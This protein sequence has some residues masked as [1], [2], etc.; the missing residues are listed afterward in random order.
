[1]IDGGATRLGPVRT[2]FLVGALAAALSMAAAA[3]ALLASRRFFFTDDYVTYYMPG[4]REIARLLY[5]GQFPFLTDRLWN[6]GALLQEGQF[7]LFNPVSL[8]LYA[9][10]GKIDDLRLAAAVFSLAH[11]GIFGGGAY[12][13]GRTIGCSR[14]HAFLV[15]L[16]APL[17]DFVFYWAATNWVSILVSM[18]WLAWAWGFLILTARR[19]AYV[20]PA[21]AMVAMVLV[22]GWPFADLALLISVFLAADVFLLSGFS[23]SRLA[24]AAWLAVALAAGVLLAAPALAP[25]A[26]YDAGAGRPVLFG[27]WASELAGLL[28][29]GVP[30]FVTHWGYFTPYEFKDVPQPTVFVAWFAPLALVNADWKTLMGKPAS[31]LVLLLAGTLAA[32]SMFPGVWQFRWMFRLLPYYQFAVLALSCLALTQADEQG[33]RWRFGWSSRLVLAEIGLAI[34]QFMPLAWF[35]VLAGAAILACAAVGGRLIA[36]RD[37]AWTVFAVATSMAAFVGPLILAANAGYPRFPAASAL[38]TGAAV[39]GHDAEGPTR[40]TI[41]EGGEIAGRGLAAW[42]A[43]APAG[44]SLY[45][46]GTNLVGYSNIPRPP[47]VADFCAGYIGP[48]CANLATRVTRPIPPTGRSLL[49]LTATSEIIVE[50]RA[51]ADALVGSVGPGWTLSRGAIGEWRLVRDRAPGLVTYA[52]PGLSATLVGRTPSR[53]MLDVRNAAPRRGLLVV[54][55]AWYPTWRAR[56]NGARIPT[57][58]LAGVLVSAAIPANAHGRLDLVFRPSGLSTGIVLAI[59]GALMLLLTAIAP[60]LV[61]VPVGRLSRALERCRSKRSLDDETRP[62]LGFAVDAR[63]VAADD[64]QG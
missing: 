20:W 33:R 61:D 45:W 1:V 21:A 23:A 11:I 52:T 56:L 9:I 27:G 32:L 36:R 47:F 18:A 5:E 10:I 58:P 16:L 39:P 8:A 59:V 3:S 37:L 2:D 64:S 62:T 25:L 41:F 4:F 17:S 46:P 50:K 57:A 26:L 54:A 19:R 29:V 6:G 30:N 12:F 44:T 55:R 24:S 31:R 43:Y 15:G 38:L 22:S 51:D 13:A 53:V 42:K 35:Y 7:G 63:D 48:R 49:D 60:S 14:R 40:L 34:V 28:G